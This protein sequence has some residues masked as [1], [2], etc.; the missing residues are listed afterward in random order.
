MYY[1]SIIFQEDVKVLRKYIKISHERITLNVNITPPTY[2]LFVLFGSTHV[3]NYSYS[4]EKS[5]Y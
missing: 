2:L 5:Q 4:L 3:L 1:S